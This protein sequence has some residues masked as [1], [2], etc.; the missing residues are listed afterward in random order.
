MYLIILG[1]T[2]WHES[3]MRI[4]HTKQCENLCAMKR[5]SNTVL[6]FVTSGGGVVRQWNVRWDK[7]SFNISKMFFTGTSVQAEKH[8]T[9]KTG[10]KRSE[11]EEK[12]NPPVEIEN[13]KYLSWRNNTYEED[14]IDDGTIS[15]RVY[16]AL[17]GVT[18]Y[19]IEH[20]LSVHVFVTRECSR[21]SGYGARFVMTLE[22]NVKVPFCTHIPFGDEAV[23]NGRAGDG[24]G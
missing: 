17:I 21:W 4:P 16:N 2:M 8:K 1:K 6:Y 15:S 18:C 9:Q 19:F 3:K 12:K 11:K 24:G 10:K 23:S 5:Q 14:Y 7:I 20:V 22:M 13:V